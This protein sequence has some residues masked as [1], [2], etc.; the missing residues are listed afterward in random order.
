MDGPIL[1]SVLNGDHSHHAH[2]RKYDDVSEREHVQVPTTPDKALAPREGPP[3]PGISNLRSRLQEMDETAYKVE[4]EEL[5]DHFEEARPYSALNGHTTTSGIQGRPPISLSNGSMSSPENDKSV[6]PR[7]LS[8]PKSTRVD[9]AT[10]GS[11][12]E[13]VLKL[14]VDRLQD[15][16][17]S[18]E[19]LPLRPVDSTLS[20]EASSKQPSPYN[21]DLASGKD[22]GQVK[23]E[24]DGFHPPPSMNSL[25]LGPPIGDDH[26]RARNL[27]IETGNQPLES[28]GTPKS[29][30]WAPQ[31]AVSTPTSAR[32][33]QSPHKSEKIRPSL[34]LPEASSRVEGNDGRRYSSSGRPL[35]SPMP[36]SIPLPPVSIPTYLQL[37]LSSQRPSPLYIHRSANS[38]FPYESSR[39]K[40]E[41]LLNFLL[42]PPHL[43]SVLWF[44]TVACLDSWL[45]IFTILPLRLLKSFYL[46][47]KSW[48]VNLATEV[49]FV[50]NFVYN[51]AGRMWTRRR[52]SLPPNPTRRTSGPSAPD[53]RA[54]QNPLHGRTRYHQR[55]KSV[56]STLL[57]DD[58]ADMLKGLL[59]IST[60]LILLRLDA[61]R[62]YHWVRGQ[63]AIK[64]YVIYN[65]LEVCDR[66][67]SAIGQD[68][69]E[70]LFSRETLERKAD[71]H[72]KVLRPFWLFVLALIYCV[73]HA[74]ALF[75]QVIT[76]NVAV[77]SY[78]NALITLLMSNQF[79]EIKGTVFKKFEKENLF[80]LTCADVVE[81]FQL[82]H[83]LIIIA[84][85]NIVE[86]GGLNRGLAAYT[87][88]SS[89]TASATST[90]NGS[91]PLTA[92]FPPRSASSIVPS[93]F[94]LLPTMVES[95]TSFAPA[96]SQVL[97][98]FLVVL[99]SEML[100]DW[101]KHA[102]INKFNNTRPA[103]YDR[104][105][106]VLAKDYYTNAFSEQN[107]TKRLGLPVIPLSCLFIRASV[108]TYQMF[109]AAW[110][111]S[112]SPSSSTSLE[113]I[114]EDYSAVRSTLPMTTGVAISRTVDD[115][116]RSIPNVIM[117]SSIVT[118]MTTL[119]VFLLFFLIL[120]ACK[121]VL[122]MLLLAFAR[123]RYHSMK[124]REKSVIHHVEGGRR[125]GGW[126]VVEVDEDKRRWIYEDDPAGLRALRERDERE[127][128]KQQRE[129][130]KAHG[131]E[132]FDKV[133]RYEMVAKRIW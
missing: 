30:P 123:S 47:T 69:L 77:N 22:S 120:L 72:S 66:L 67:F 50:S 126:G 8:T 93:A 75:Y 88:A 73:I 21:A 58:K 52:G 36:A 112:S 82:W 92:A 16:T 97:G 5:Q 59:I 56:P 40:I 133:K 55:T 51:G 114:H 53:T 74:T 101:L 70:C 64:L 121:L 43:E 85:R 68:V 25:V 6:S 78:S 24:K 84:A 81:R 106:D 39:A 48:G 65:I 98:P 41:R 29:R 116:I 76:L 119:L 45:Y 18:P 4:K 17:S 95:I 23:F 28:S 90:S 44:G 27:T 89:A 113:S 14:S 60:C 63:A 94:T 13:N 122:G 110:V 87:A 19:S 12:L 103:I 37:E 125:V 131:V 86:T 107:L 11:K 32:N 79:V 96:V 34:K 105:L 15:L 62:M 118:H 109:M 42:L 10:S 57:P 35:P 31:R 100:V 38:D 3:D 71:G 9:A 26:R 104:F 91:I 111:P 1:A 102:Y 61:S 54:S 46:L 20:Q 128:Q 115:I 129:K 33:P 99:G 124:L 130:E 7:M 132:A 83:M 80:Q 108:Q 49:N 2:S 127:R 117:K